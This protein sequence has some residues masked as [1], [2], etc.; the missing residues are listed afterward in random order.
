MAARAPSALALDSSSAWVDDQERLCTRSQC[1][2][3]RSSSERPAHAKV[4][5]ARAGF[6]VWRARTRQLCASAHLVCA[7]RGA[8]QRRCR[9]PRT[10]SARS[11][12]AIPPRAATRCPQ[13][14]CPRKQRLSGRF[15]QEAARLPLTEARARS[16]PGQ[17]RRQSNRA[18]GR[19]CARTGARCQGRAPRLCAARVGQHYAAAAAPD[20]DVRGGVQWRPAEA[21]PAD[22]TLDEQ[23]LHPSGGGE[24]ETPRE[25]AICEIRVVPWQVWQQ[26]VRAAAGP[27]L[28]G[29]PCLARGRKGV[30]RSKTCIVS[31]WYRPR[32][33]R[34][35]VCEPMRVVSFQM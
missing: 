25:A 14:L 2:S 21:V 16:A 35:A 8:W 17:G 10:P 31:A 23:L 13:G 9:L 4:K 18:C 22:T 12:D 27:G 3:S 24:E 29:T 6:R 7:R 33:C 26:G 20:R 19:V 11:A 32:A 1:P 28:Q 15:T 34:G 5:G 30:C